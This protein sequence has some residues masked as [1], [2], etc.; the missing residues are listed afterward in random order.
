MIEDYDYDPG[1]YEGYVHE[2]DNDK[3]LA[4]ARLEHLR[5]RNNA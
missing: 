5:R 3:L 1:P 2:T 4:E